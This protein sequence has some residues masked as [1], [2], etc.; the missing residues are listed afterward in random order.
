MS[1]TKKEAIGAIIV[2]VSVVIMFKAAYWLEHIYH[3]L[4]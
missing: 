2:V 1:K 3:Q 4:S